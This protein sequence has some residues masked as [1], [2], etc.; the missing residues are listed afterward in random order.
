MSTK[1]VKRK[2]HACAVCRQL[3]VRV[4]TDVTV[5]TDDRRHSGPCK[6]SHIREGLD[7]LGG[8]W[9]VY[10]L[11]STAHDRPSAMAISPAAAASTSRFPAG[12][13]RDRTRR[14]SRSTS[15]PS[16]GRTPGKWYGTRGAR[17]TVKLRRVLMAEGRRTKPAPRILWLGPMPLVLEWLVGV[18]D[19]LA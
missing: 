3:K 16:A 17:W 5:G 1:V 12:F 4:R 7:C 6:W 2:V 11:T 10:A 15:A 18:G 8:C 19:G 13:R 14:P 9:S